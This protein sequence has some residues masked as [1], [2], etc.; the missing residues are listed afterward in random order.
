MPPNSFG[1]GADVTE[2]MGVF[3]AL[4]RREESKTTTLRWKI[5][6]ILA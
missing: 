1:G 6:R 4:K 2:E 3:H 5:R